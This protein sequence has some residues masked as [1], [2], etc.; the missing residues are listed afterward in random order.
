MRQDDADSES[1]VMPEKQEI[2]LIYITSVDTSRELITALPYQPRNNLCRAPSHRRDRCGRRR[3]GVVMTRKGG[4][5]KSVKPPLQGSQ[6]LQPLYRP[7]VICLFLF[8]SPSFVSSAPAHHP[9]HQPV[10]I[11]IM[12]IFTL[13]LCGR[14]EQVNGP[15]KH[16]RG[17]ACN[18][19]TGLSGSVAG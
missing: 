11:F 10:P 12:S 17:C 3:A 2:L 4:S 16:A 1:Q 6:A 5:Y 15:P 7:A 14:V 13:P 9:F 19:K 18:Q 8:R